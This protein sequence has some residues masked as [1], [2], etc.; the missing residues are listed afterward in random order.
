MS[1]M[2]EKM[3][4]GE[5]YLPADEDIVKEQ[6]VYQDRLCEYNLTKPSEAE[7]RAAMLK[8]MLGSCGKGVYIEAP[9]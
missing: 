4:T 5:L 9:F 2:K 8:E 6:V 3:H 7:K 1:Q